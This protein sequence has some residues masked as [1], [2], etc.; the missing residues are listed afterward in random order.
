LAQIDRSQLRGFVQTVT[1]LIDPKQ[2]GPTL[3][4][5][6]LF[7]DL[8]PPRFRAEAVEDEEITLCNCWKINYG[9]ISSR[10]NYR[11]DDK[12]VAIAEVADMKAAGGSTLVELTVGGL[13]PNPAGLVDI[14]RATGV[15][16]V[17]GCGHY[18]DEYQDDANR[19]RSVDDF[20]AEIIG[21]ITQGAWGTDVRAGIIGEIG[22]QAPWTD[23]E[24]NVMCGALA[25]QR[26]TG[27]AINVHP[28]RHPDQPQEVMD[29]IRAAGHPTERVIISHIDRT[30]FD[31]DRI[32][33][34]AETGCVLEFDLFGWETSFYGP[35]PSVDMQND[36]QRIEWLRLLLD[37]GHG[38]QVVISQDICVKTRLC[39][40]GG[41]GYQHIFAN[42]VPLM[43]RHDFSEAEIQAILVDTP[44]RLLTFV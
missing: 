8:N 28:G 34:L 32:L 6:H 15:N 4:H 41:H 30:I 10:L 9:Q 16:I 36:A 7:I 12:A 3:M 14:A 31:A 20:A 42:V 13:Q 21:Q 38:D 11:L 39:S 25:A 26:E 35:Q 2:V 27:A 37:R 40:Y 19:S 23:L 5:E 22:C 24:K 17:M 29:F 33:R 1:G 18:V 44:T 43:R